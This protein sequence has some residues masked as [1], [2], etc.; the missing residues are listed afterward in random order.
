MN[1]MEKVIVL[2]AVLHVLHHRNGIA[3]LKQNVK[4][5]EEIGVVIIVLIIHVRLALLLNHG[6]VMIKQVVQ[7][8]EMSGVA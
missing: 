8:Q 2:T 5:Q 1:H 7:E 4:Q 6:I 3:I